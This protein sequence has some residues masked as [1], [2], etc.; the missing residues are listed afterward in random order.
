MSSVH[1]IASAIAS[2]RNSVRGVRATGSP[3][4]GR[5]GDR[6]YEGRARFPAP[7]RV[8]VV[9]LTGVARTA[10]QQNGP[11]SVRSGRYLGSVS[12]EPFPFGKVL[13]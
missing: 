3:R 2:V 7:V 4:A 10:G 6:A 8:R 5:S 9:R 12:S 11:E 13:T 1:E